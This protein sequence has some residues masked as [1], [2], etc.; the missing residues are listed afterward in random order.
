ME[1]AGSAVKDL[2]VVEG[3][4]NNGTTWETFLE[5]Y[6]AFANANWQSA[7]DNG[8]SVG[9]SLYK[10]RLINLTA[11]GKFVAGDNVLIRFRLTADGIKNGWGWAIDNLSIQ[12]PVTGIEKINEAVLT[13]YPNPVTNGTLTVALARNGSGSTATIQ[14]INSLG[15]IMIT[16]R[17]ELMEDINKKEYTV[18]QWHDGIYFLIV[19]FDDGTRLARKFIK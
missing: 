6:A 18:G 3:S 11:S 19:D 16:D 4:K 7:F 12:G 8:I 5:P 13:M 15:Q 14:I 2:V 17:I 9:S 1:Y 10:P